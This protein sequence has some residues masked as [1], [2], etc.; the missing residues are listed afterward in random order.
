MERIGDDGGHSGNGALFSRVYD[1]FLLFGMLNLKGKYRI[2]TRDGIRLEL[3]HRNGRKSIVCM[4]INYMELREFTKH[5]PSAI[6]A[7]VFTL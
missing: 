6:V 7:R 4:L 1:Y 5:L 3:R 2:G